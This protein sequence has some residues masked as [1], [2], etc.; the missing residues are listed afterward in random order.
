MEISQLASA[1]IAGLL[2][3]FAPCLV[4]LFP[5]YFSVITGFT[6]ADLYGLD[7]GKIRARVLVASLFFILGFTL[8]FTLLGATGSIIGKLIDTHLPILVRLSGVFLIVLGVAQ[9]GILKF[10]S[11]RFDFAWNIQKRLT[12]MGYL[13][14][15]VTG[16]ASGLSWIPCVGPLLSPILLLAARSE[17]VLSGSLLLFVYSLGIMLPFLVAGLFFPQVAA[18]LH[19]YRHTLHYF[20]LATGIFLILFGLILLFEKYQIIINSINAATLSI[21]GPF[22]DFFFTAPSP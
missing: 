6:F 13:T 2:S 7:F 14:A 22:Y 19:K 18:N 21:R 12:K 20:S 10:E 17:T 16:V 15:V 5:T 11:M 4:P 3:F 9:M 1:Y 8:V